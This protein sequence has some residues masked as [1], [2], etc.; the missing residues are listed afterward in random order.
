MGYYKD[1]EKPLIFLISQNQAHF[2]KEI[3]QNERV[4]LQKLEFFHHPTSFLIAPFGLQNYRLF[5]IQHCEH[6][7][8]QKIL[9]AI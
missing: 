8:R 3:T 9:N 1:R 7:F 5:K 4:S 2:L 6:S